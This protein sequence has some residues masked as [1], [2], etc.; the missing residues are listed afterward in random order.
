MMLRLKVVSQT[1]S[2]SSLSSCLFCRSCH[3]LGRVN[4]I[5]LTSYCLL[6]LKTAVVK[7]HERK[8]LAGSQEVKVHAAGDD[9]KV[10]DDKDI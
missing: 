8:L 7:P 1:T 9:D 5:V 2:V 6:W 4:V 10:M 3:S